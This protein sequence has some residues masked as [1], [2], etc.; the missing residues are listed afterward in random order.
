M[1]ILCVAVTCRIA[2]K[3]RQEK[4]NFLKEFKR[5][6]F[7]LIY[8]AAIPLYWLGI[9]YAGSSAGAAFILAIRSSVDLIVLK[10]DYNSVALLMADNVFYRIA[11]DICYVLVI[12]NAVL[13][14]VTLLG[15]RVANQI[16]ALWF[17]RF[18]KK[19][20]VVIGYNE[21]NKAIIESI[22]EEHG[23]TLLLTE[24]DASALDFAFCRKVACMRYSEKDDLKT[25]LPKLF[26]KFD[27]KTVNV[28]INT[29]DDVRNIVCVEQ[30]SEIIC[31]RDLGQYSIDD[32]RGL[33]GYVFGLPKNVSA[34][35]HFVEKTNGCVHYVNKYKLI[36]MDFVGKYPLTEFMNQDHIDYDTATVRKEVS[37]NVVMIGFGKTNQQIFLTS[38]ANNQFPTLE[39]GKLTEKPV[40][41]WIYDKKDARNDKN[42][43]HNYYRYTNELS[44]TPQDY[45]PLPPQPANAKFCE[46]DVNDV[47][48]YNSIRENLTVK[49]DEIPLNYIVIAYG[50]D[51]ENLDFAEKIVAKLKE[52]G[53]YDVTKVFVKVR[54]HL[55]CSEV[56]AKELSKAGFLPFGDE[57]EVVYNVSQIVAEKKEVMAK[58]RHLCYA[59]TGDMSVEEETAAKATALK[60]WYSMAE[61]QRESNIY[62]CLSIRMKLHLLGFDYTAKKT[63]EKNDESEKPSAKEEYMRRYQKDDEIIYDKTKTK[64]KG[65]E[66]V[67]YSNDIK[68]GTVRYNLTWQEHARWNAYMITSGFIPTTIEGIKLGKDKNMGMRMHANIT[69]FEG[70]K[71]Y[72]KI[73]AYINRTDEEHEDVI[74]FDYQLMDDVVWLLENNGYEIIR[75]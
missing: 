24:K 51:M 75:R 58:D 73:S 63:N 20:F 34:F 11:V 27:T 45:L 65:R 14:T 57:G 39:E 44:G 10:L 21:Q 16:K 48:F 40:N 6:Q 29:G 38:V 64:V 62:A 55:L 53:L 69:T 67:L 61:V 8:F 50:S 25:L 41:Y 17:T 1:A 4:L 28:I 22:C 59:L 70:L 49:S 2:S 18:A 7:A 74:R 36:A 23:N 43:N 52:W 15:R 3:G 30:L 68:Y 42:L 5:G 26:K 72:R 33:K 54:N 32:C 13:F 12:L 37:L 35:L 9:R 46:L 56:V 60:K 19:T 31:A 47:Q 66:V 71:E